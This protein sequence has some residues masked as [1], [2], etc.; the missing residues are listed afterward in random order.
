MRSRFSHPVK[1]R[2]P[3]HRRSRRVWGAE[4]D[5][6][7]FLKCW[8][9]GFLI[10]THLGLSTGDGSG[11]SYGDRALYTDRIR[12]SADRYFPSD[13]RGGVTQLYWDNPFILG[14]IPK[15]G[16][17]G[18]PA[19]VSTYTPRLVDVAPGCCP[20]CGTRNLP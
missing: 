11:L 17:D 19:S 12:P 16:M 8:N 2:L 20:L 3:Q 4:E 6:G 13:L 5:T 14:T 15:N 10:D 9:C 18:T 7:R 1:S